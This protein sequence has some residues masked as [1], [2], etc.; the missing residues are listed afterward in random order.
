MTDPPIPF[1]CWPLAFLSIKANNNSNSSS[2]SNSSNKNNNNSNN[3]NENFL[4]FVD[5]TMG[6]DIN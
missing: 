6:T 1:L 4:S 2:T 5:D 3:N